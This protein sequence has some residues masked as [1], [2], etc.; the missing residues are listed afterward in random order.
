MIVLQ[1]Q[2]TD[3]LKFHSTTG[4]VKHYDTIQNFETEN[5]QFVYRIF[6]QKTPTLHNGLIQLKH[7]LLNKEYYLTIRDKKTNKNISI[8]INDLNV[9][10]NQSDYIINSK[11]NN[12]TIALDS[13][14]QTHLRKS[15]SFDKGIF[16]I[17]NYDTNKNILFDL[18]DK[19]ILVIKNA[20]KMYS[21]E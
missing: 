3:N 4:Y 12:I 7:E 2:S 21:N 15:L 14:E 19:D 13:T 17:H 18:S 16:F 6:Y 1:C 20:F 11:L 8:K 10:L 9:F 5:E